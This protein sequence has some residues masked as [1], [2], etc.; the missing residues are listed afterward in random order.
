MRG[1]EQ[2][3]KST[4]EWLLEQENKVLENWTVKKKKL[5][6]C[7][8]FV[9]FERSAKQALEWIHDTG[10][11]YLST[12]TTVGES[13]EESEELFKEYNDFKNTAKETKD[14]VKLLIQL[15]DNL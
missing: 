10:E 7:Q 4:L 8:Q 13:R 1:P 2:K 3:V 15:A 11:F 9:L 5:D 12:H 6:Q 14:K